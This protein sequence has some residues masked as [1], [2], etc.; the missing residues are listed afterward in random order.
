M[1]ELSQIKGFEGVELY[2]STH[3]FVKKERKILHILLHH[4]H[5]IEHRRLFSDY[6]CG[7]LHE[8]LVKVYKYSDDQAYRRA[9]AMRLLFELPQIEEKILS[10]E[11]TLTNMNIA[12]SLFRQEAIHAESFSKDKKLEIIEQISGKSSKQA[13]RIALSNSSKP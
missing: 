9:A 4:F 12:Q 10:G 11:L 7:S 2:E 3:F 1:F 8:M 13:E 5:E 6:A